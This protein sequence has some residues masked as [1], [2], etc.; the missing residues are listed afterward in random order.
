MATNTEI[1][2][3]GD[4]ICSGYE[5][6]SSCAN[7]CRNIDDNSST[8]SVR[9]T[10]GSAEQCM[11]TT[12]GS[13]RQGMTERALRNVLP[14]VRS[15]SVGL[16]GFKMTGYYEYFTG[17]YAVSSCGAC[18][19]TTGTCGSCKKVTVFLS[20]LELRSAAVWTG[21]LG[22]DN[23]NNKPVTSFTVNSTVYTLLSGAGLAITTDS[24]YRRLSSGVYVYKRFSW[25]TTNGK[26][27]NDGTNDWEYLGSYY[28]YMQVPRS[29][30]TTSTI[31]TTYK[32]PQY[33]SGSSTYVYRRFKKDGAPAGN[34][35]QGISRD[36]ADGSEIIIPLLQPTSTTPQSTFD[37]NVAKI[38]ARFNRVDNGGFFMK[39]NTPTEALVQLAQSHF[40]A[41]AAGTSPYTTPDA[42][43]GCRSRVVILLSDG[44]HNIGSPP[45]GATQTLYAAYPS[46]PIKTYAVALPNLTSTALAELDTIADAGDDGE[47]NGSATA[48]SSNNEDDLV[49]ALKELFAELLQGDYTTTQA[50]V[51][52]SAGS[53]LTGNVALV[54]STEYPSWQGRLRAYNLL[55]ASTDPD[56][57]MW[58]A[59]AVLAART[60]PRA[61][62]TGPN[63]S[64][65]TTPIA[66]STSNLT[67]VKAAWSRSGATL[68]TDA[69][70]TATINYITQK[71]LAP[72]LN[73]VPA[74]VAAPPK[75]SSSNL[76][77]HDTFE[78]TYENREALAY[79]ASNDGVLH[80]FRIADGTEA[81]GYISP[82]AWP[83][84][85]A[86]YKAGGQDLDLT[87]FR[88]ILA[89]SPR[90][91]D[92]KV[93]S[94]AAWA[95]QLALN[96][97]PG[98][99]QFVVLDIT[100]PSTCTSGVCTLNSPP[101]T[102]KSY[103]RDLGTSVTNYIAETWS[104]P[105][106]F[107][108]KQGANT[109]SAAAYASGYI[110]PSGTGTDER[111][112]IY[113]DT[114][115]TG[116]SASTYT[117]APL[118]STNAPKVDY[119]VVADSVAVINPDDQRT[120]VATYQV[121]ANGRFMRFEA[122]KTTP[123]SKVKTLLDGSSGG[124]G[125]PHPFLLAPAAIYRGSSRATFAVMSGAF[126]EEGA[127]MS[128][129]SYE[130]K[131]WLRT[132]DNGTL[133]SSDSF[134]CAIS[135]V[136]GTACYNGGTVA[137]DCTAPSVRA[138][139]VSSPILVENKLNSSNIEAF[140]LYYDPP[141]AQ[142][143]GNQIALGTSY[144]FRVSTTGATQ[145]LMKM[146]TYPN[147][148]ASGLS[149]VGGGTEIVVSKSA[150][151]TGAQA[152]VETFSG[153]ALSGG[154]SGTPGMES[155]RE[156]R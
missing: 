30:A 14:L 43:A 156:V 110:P 95:T 89:N 20:E 63:T 40:A 123:S 41:R 50:G 90:V 23:T 10:A 112:Y 130:S 35:M 16:A 36:P 67:A 31:S 52:T 17:S 113:Q 75:Y 139:P 12:S 55:K 105:A 47:M 100:N 49:E 56:F 5:T 15:A 25:S 21:G 62:Y 19:G 81:F 153:G 76:S 73:S 27:Y 29:S 151:G 64:G 155:W 48:I 115:W 148:I 119:A 152:S 91:E 74:V 122:G 133:Q 33:V 24:L 42:A 149:I 68:P 84:I 134:T 22:W 124:A 34:P 86:L 144:V 69:E 128:N 66:V 116:S 1:D 154:S 118:T 13:S 80:A 108:V 125:A 106:F 143:S 37:D 6:T 101:F 109:L 72:L 28:A 44:E 150:K 140:F 102:T 98:G 2:K 142:C 51:A 32:G 83:R 96:Y 59:G 58:E 26:A 114:L 7:D 135:Q 45:S 53:T 146:K 145:N 136:C 78:T 147:T 39:T 77:G 38:V 131:V 129:A 4:G 54:P 104:L 61:L 85:Y 121:D 132:D 70:V 127:W 87:R 93:S 103:S 8:A 11:N 120:I 107:Y 92:V 117:L 18:S 88:W 94:S 111:Y 9:Q 46:N 138:L 79:V 97:G 137:A 71:K 82:D 126:M 3:C 57:L 65:A 141:A 60:S 99:D